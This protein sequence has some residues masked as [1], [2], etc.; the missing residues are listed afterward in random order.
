MPRIFIDHQKFSTQVYGGISRY[1]AN[2][3]DALEG[4]EGFEALL[5]VLQ[6]RNE[7]LK[8]G[9]A[10]LFSRL[11][12]SKFGS[13]AYSV[14]Q[15]YSKYLL[16]KSDFDL[17]HP[18]YYDPYYF[19]DLKK[20]LVITVHDMTH[21]RLPEYFWAEDPL[22]YQ[23]RLNIERADKIIAISETTRQDVITYAGV[24]PEKIELIY[25]GIDL[26]HP[27]DVRPVPDLPPNYILYVGD[28]SGFKNFYLF[29]RAFREFS[30]KFPDIEL[31]LSGGGRLAVAEKEYLNN[32]GI[33]GKVR[34]YHVTDEE[35]NFLYSNARVFVY[36]SLYEGFGF[37]ILEAFRARCPV[38]LSDIPCF[39]EIAADGAEYFASKDLDSLV[40]ALERVICDSTLRSE[41]VA[42][43]EERV[44]A[45]PLERS[46]QRTL[47][48]YE[49][50]AAAPAR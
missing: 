24:D 5:G 37:P 43:G 22:T 41:L 45:F 14:N 3:L 8:A 15:R 38:V 10:D 46:V 28:R 20:P 1:F 30:E 26:K 9:R 25:H 16:K 33:T 7:Y 47:E 27:V 17:F 48:L 42:R 44:K 13:W 4:Q 12:G 50:L 39:T 11:L 23:K 29:A 40:A 49:R 32:L 35:L 19:R 18:T 34:H 21:E 31:V 2:I 36:P 6:T